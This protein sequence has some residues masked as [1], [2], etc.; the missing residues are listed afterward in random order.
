MTIKVAILG[1]GTIGAVH[2]RNVDAHPK[3]D[4]RFVADPNMDLATALVDKFGGVAVASAEEAVADESVDAVI[5]A[6]STIAHKDHV[7]LAAKH[8]RAL[9]CEK[10]VATSL[11]DATECL[12]A[13]RD[14]E[15]TAM[16]GFNRRLDRAYEGLKQSIE[17]GH[18][19]KV[20]ALRLVSRSD[21]LP[22]PEAA[23]RSGGTLR[24]KGAHFYDLASWLADADPVEINGMGACLIDPRYADYGDV[25]TAILS[26]RLENGALA[27]FDFGRRT[28]YGYEEMIE[29]FGSDGLLVADRQPVAGISQLDGQGWSNPG[30]DA[31]WRQRFAETYVRELDVLAEAIEDQRPV[32]ATLEDGVRAQAVAEAAVEALSSGATVQIEP[33]WR[34]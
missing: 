8:R 3:Y 29:V 12:A 9:L 1:A 27:G 25:D 20:E 15:M 23:S 31:S 7:L 24:E 14:V 26:L 21:T 2:A 6:S 18:V 16:T 13:A 17:A 30:L 32:H 19:G 28:V 4:L 33:V 34:V 10:P 5:V 22:Q 11:S